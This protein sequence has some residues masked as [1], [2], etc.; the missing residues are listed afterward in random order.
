MNL[1]RLIETEDYI[2]F[3][4][5]PIVTPSGDVFVKSLSF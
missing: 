5:V 3:T 1:G 2:R 4:D